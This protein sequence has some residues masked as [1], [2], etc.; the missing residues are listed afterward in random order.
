MGCLSEFRK[1]NSDFL[2]APIVSSALG[3]IPGAAFG[4]WFGART[5]WKMGEQSKLNAG[6]DDVLKNTNRAISGAAGIC[7][8]MLPL[9]KLP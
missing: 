1:I 3:A 8:K 6:L 7:N 5:A 9:K 4:A 2:K